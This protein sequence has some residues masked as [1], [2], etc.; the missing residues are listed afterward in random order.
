MLSKSPGMEA[1]EAR[2]EL[3]EDL[4][5]SGGGKS[6]DKQTI[7]VHLL[8]IRVSRQTIAEQNVAHLFQ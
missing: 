4:V 7:T 5:A 1:I 3:I 2:L 8:Q 6:P